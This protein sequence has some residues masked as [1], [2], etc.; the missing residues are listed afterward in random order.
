MDLLGALP[1]PLLLSVQVDGESGQADYDVMRRATKSAV[2]SRQAEAHRLRPR[3]SLGRNS[4][5]GRAGL[6]C[7]VGGHCAESV[8]QPSRVPTTGRSR[9][10]L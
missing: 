5:P 7:S 6:I 2:V 9:A 1:F 3:S 10:A 8:R 4:S